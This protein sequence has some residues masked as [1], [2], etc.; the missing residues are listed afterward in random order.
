MFFRG[1][2]VFLCYVD[3]RILA[4][5]DKSLIDKAIDNLPNTIKAKAKCIIEDQGDNKDYLGINFEKLKDGKIKSHNH[6]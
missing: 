1:K 2:I 4:S 3:N 5:L 6:I